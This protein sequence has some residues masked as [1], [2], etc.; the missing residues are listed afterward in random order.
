MIRTSDLATK[1]Q[2]FRN[3]ILADVRE[4]VAGML[5]SIRP[6]VRIVD[7]PLVIGARG[8]AASVGDHVFFRLGLNGLVTILTWSLGGTVGGTPTAG[9]VTLDVL[10]GATLATAASICG[11]SKPALAA[12]IEASDQ[13]PAVGWTVQLTDPQWILAKVSSTGGTLEVISLTLRCAVDSR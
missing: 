2:A 3:G 11:T 10:V 12:A 13:P 6:G 5:G 7:V 9:T 8:S 4:M 1:R